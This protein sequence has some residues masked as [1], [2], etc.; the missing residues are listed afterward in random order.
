MYTLKNFFFI[1]GT[2]WILTRE[3]KPSKDDILAA[4]NTLELAGIESKY[5]YLTKQANCDVAIN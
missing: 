5:M 1:I 3:Q 2:A 4:K